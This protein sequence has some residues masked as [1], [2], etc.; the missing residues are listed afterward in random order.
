MGLVAADIDFGMAVMQSNN[1]IFDLLR[2]VIGKVAAAI[3]GAGTLVSVLAT[4][5]GEYLRPRYYALKG[6]AGQVGFVGL[7]EIVAEARNIAIEMNVAT[8][9][10]GPFLPSLDFLQSFPDPDGSGPEPAGLRVKTGGEPVYMDF[11]RL[12]SH[13]A[14]CDLA[15]ARKR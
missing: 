14:D 9:A 10:W 15:Q 3:P 12:Q 5:I 11:V 7:D 1:P 8:P 13:E 2:D 6:T 4:A